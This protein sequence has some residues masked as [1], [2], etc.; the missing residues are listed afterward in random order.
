MREKP[1]LRLCAGA[2]GDMALYRDPY[3]LANARRADNLAGA[4]ARFPHPL[5]AIRPPAAR[6][7]L[8]SIAP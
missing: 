3:P 7:R 1:H 8:R 2:H 4:M 6:E 5:I